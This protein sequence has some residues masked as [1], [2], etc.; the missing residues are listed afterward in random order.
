MIY[1]FLEQ[2]KN[3]KIFLNIFKDYLPKGISNNSCIHISG[4]EESGKTSLALEIANKN[5]ENTFIYIDTY[6]ELTEE[7]LPNNMYLFRSNDINVILDFLNSLSKNV[8]DFLIIDS[9]SNLILKEEIESISYI[10]NRYEYFNAAIM[11]IISKCCSLNICLILFNTLNG[12]GNPSNFSIQ[13]K[14]QC[15]LDISILNTEENENEYI[16]SLLTNKNKIS[17]TNKN[18]VISIKKE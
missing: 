1:N 17:K 4:G 14:K 2:N 7:K 12:N 6:F 15:L 13:I 3:E 16:L 8:V 9:I 18:I 5:P 10:K 11:K